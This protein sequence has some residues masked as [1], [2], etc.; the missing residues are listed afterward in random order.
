MGVKAR[1]RAGKANTGQDNYGYVRNGE[2]YEIVPEEAKWITQVVGWYIERV[3]M[4]EIRRRLIEADAPQ[5]GSSI[6]RKVRWAITSIQAIL[7]QAEIYATGVKLYSRDGEKFRLP[8]PIILDQATYQKVLEVREA[9]KN[10]PAHNM[11]RDYL[12]AGIMYCE[13]GRLWQGRANSYTR[14]NRRGDK[15]LRKTFYPTYY[16]SERL[17]EMIR[18]DCPRTIG[19]KKADQVLWMKVCEVLEQ[20]PF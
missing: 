17:P 14:K 20:I 6:P 15:V 2:T 11:R 4:L 5:K 16:C 18:P 1:L 7:R 10:Y 13:C 12:M 9:N 8:V 19:G 3:P